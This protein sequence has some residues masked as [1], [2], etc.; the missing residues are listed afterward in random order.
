[1]VNGKLWSEEEIE[2][3]R[4][5]YQDM[6][7]KE[8]AEELNRSKHSV[9]SRR[10]IEG[11]NKKTQD[12]EPWDEEETAFLRE[13]Y[14]DLTAS[15]IADRLGRKV[16]SVHNKAERIDLR[17][18]VRQKWSEEEVAFLREHN[19][20]MDDS[21]LADELDRTERSV[22]SKRGE[23]GLTESRKWTESDVE[24]LRDN[25]EDMSD[26]QIADR[27]DH[28]VHG[29][30][31]KR[32]Q[33]G[34]TF[35]NF[36]ETD[37]HFDWEELCVKIAESIHGEVCYHEVFDDGSY[38]PDIFVPSKNLVID[39][40][41]GVYDGSVDDVRRYLEIDGVERV[42]L[43]SYRP[44]RQRRDGVVIK[45][46]EKLKREVGEELAEEIEGFDTESSD[47]GP[48]QLSLVEVA[49]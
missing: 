26:G 5:N 29:T 30:K 40:K 25:W 23:L 8:I 44:Y 2:F 3:V 35:D 20:D 31:K 27:L 19:S 10:N 14:D 17:K 47:A 9:R 39:A 6:T 48:T 34:L 37:R 38:I 21:E 46:R 28:G 16:R 1:M 36:I 32:Q 33:L 24:F 43:W 42:E 22:H 11:W 15:E 49:G 45:D 13:N 41:M 7:D 4:D 18:Q 12:E